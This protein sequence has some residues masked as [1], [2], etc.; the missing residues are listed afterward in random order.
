MRLDQ[1]EQELNLFP[2]Y[3]VRRGC[4]LLRGSGEHGTYLIGLLP[5]ALELIDD[6]DEVLL[7]LA[8]ELGQL[9]NAVGGPLHAH[10]LLPLLENLA[11]V[12]DASVR[13]KVM[14]KDDETKRRKGRGTQY[15]IRYISQ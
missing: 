10:V 12:E 5:F 3:K 8:Q 2:F 1:K 11:A 6:D 15:L 9:S 14:H 4:H 13:D 7:L